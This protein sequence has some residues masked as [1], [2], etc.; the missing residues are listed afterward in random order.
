MFH[1]SEVGEEI[2]IEVR[3]AALFQDRFVFGLDFIGIG[4]GPDVLDGKVYGFE[5]EVEG[6]R[7]GCV[8]NFYLVC[9]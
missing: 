7:V 2:E 8:H 9:V 5:D 3:I 1:P 4:G 6:A